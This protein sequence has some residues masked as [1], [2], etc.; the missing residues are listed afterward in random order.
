MHQNKTMEKLLE[1]PINYL[2]SEKVSYLKTKLQLLNGE[3]FLTEDR[4]ILVSNKTTIASGFIGRWI[5][6]KIESKK[7]G[8]DLKL[9]DITDVNQ[10]K[11]GIQKNVLEITDKTGNT[12]RI[13][14]K[15]YDLWELSI[16]TYK[17]NSL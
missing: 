2:K 1:A 14:V 13:I 8:F 10:G 12:Y 11:H 4:L 9:S 3:L 5:K 15:N 6:R 17:H 16:N 7:Y